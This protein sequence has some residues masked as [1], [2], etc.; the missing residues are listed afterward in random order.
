MSVDMQV[1]LLKLNNQPKIQSHLFVGNYSEAVLLM[2]AA[3]NAS[4]S[5]YIRV[6]LC[7]LL[8]S[9]RKPMS[10]LVVPVLAR[11]FRINN[12]EFLKKPKD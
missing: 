2:K 1:L 4:P 8:F 7:F 11:R 12:K 9:Q 10:S 6:K 5:D 3:I